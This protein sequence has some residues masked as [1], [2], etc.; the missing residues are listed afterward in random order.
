MLEWAGIS[1]GEDF[2]YILQKSMKR[3]AVLSGATSLNFFGKIYGTE[4]DYWVVQGILPFEEEKAKN[5]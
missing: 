3:L 2:V 5:T 1:F 4:K